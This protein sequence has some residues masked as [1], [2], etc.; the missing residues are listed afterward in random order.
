[1]RS[2]SNAVA[3]KGTQKKVVL[4]KFKVQFVSAVFN[5]RLWNPRK[6]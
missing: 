3:T 2:G 1:M 6:Q 4:M 5:L